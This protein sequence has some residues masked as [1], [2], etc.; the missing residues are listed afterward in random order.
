MSK[1]NTA[2]LMELRNYYF[3]KLDRGIEIE[4]ILHFIQKDVLDAGQSERLQ[5]D[6]VKEQAD[7]EHKKK[8]KFY[9]HVNGAL[10][11]PDKWIL[12]GQNI[13]KA[14]PHPV[15]KGMKVVGIKY[16]TTPFL[17]SEE[18]WE[19]YCE[20]EDELSI[21]NP[22]W[23]ASRAMDFMMLKEQGYKDSTIARKY[24]LNP[25]TIKNNIEQL[26]ADRLKVSMHDEKWFRQFYLFDHKKVL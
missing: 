18:L 22:E 26:E 5:K 24:N 1:L 25:S 12:K 9:E 7:R 23:K 13:V 3:K 2:E 19:I 4:K 14:Y 10:N 11:S 6:I 20:I 21:R 15:L 8:V 16:K 17:F